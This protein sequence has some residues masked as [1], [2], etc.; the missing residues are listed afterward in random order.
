MSQTHNVSI[1]E[2]N[3]RF[4]RHERTD[5]VIAMTLAEIFLLITFVIW[6][7]YST[8]LKNPKDAA[9][10][11]EQLQRIQKENDKLSSE[12]SDTKK[13]NA[14]LERRLE[15]W[16]KQTG[17]VNPPS[18]QELREFVK[19]AGRGSPK[20]EDDNILIHATVVDGKISIK[21]LIESPSLSRWF[22]K[23]GYSLPM[24]SSTITD[25]KEIDTFLNEM[26]HFYSDSNREGPKC[27]FD[28]SLTYAS[29]EDYYDAREYFE[30]Y[31]YPA[32]I[33]RVAL[34]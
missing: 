17:F 6:Y 32:K 15:I 19:D 11:E 14:E 1:S 22:S 31:F 7:G 27:R 24:L 29:K 8:I 25:R 2:M 18:E 13:V 20:C 5:L 26:Y 34:D 21:R 23:R 3:M 33:N 4:T 16:R 12:L 10:L 30:R 28:Y 9:Y